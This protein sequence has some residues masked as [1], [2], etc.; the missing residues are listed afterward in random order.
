[1]SRTIFPQVRIS[2]VLRFISICGL[3][4]DSLSYK[5][6]RGRSLGRPQDLGT[7]IIFKRSVQTKHGLI[8]K[9]NDGDDYVELSDRGRVNILYWHSLGMM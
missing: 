4:T 6:I 5:A 2:H 9:D 7:N 8:Y 1:M 3:F